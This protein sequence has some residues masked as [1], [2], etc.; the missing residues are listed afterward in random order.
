MLSRGQQRRGEVTSVKCGPDGAHL[1]RGGHPLIDEV[2]ACT[3]EVQ[4][5]R[6]AVRE[7]DLMS[8]RLSEWLCMSASPGDRNFPRPSITRAP[9]G[10]RTPGAIAR[11]TLPVP[12]T[13]WSGITRSWSI[14]T[15]FTWANATVGGAA[16]AGAERA[17]DKIASSALTLPPNRCSDFMRGRD[18][19]EPKPVNLAVIVSEPVEKASLSI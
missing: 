18:T 17:S 5:R 19:A 13:V 15:T 12:I 4:D 7:I 2:A 14:G 8:S 10:A 3:A 9:F 16:T 1:G 6:H 11:L